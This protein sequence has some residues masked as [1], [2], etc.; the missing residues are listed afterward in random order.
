MNFTPVVPIETERLLLRPF[1]DADLAAVF[2]IYSRPDVVRYLYWNV[3]DRD[4]AR[5]ALERKTQRTSLRA[6]DDV[7]E[8]AMTVPPDPRAIGTSVLILRSEQ[9]LQGEIG[10]ILHPDVCA[11]P[12]G[13]RVVRLRRRG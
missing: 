10:W 13:G 3:W 9:H 7:V 1:T 8:L 2:D 6:D 5:K 4:E 12:Q 11:E